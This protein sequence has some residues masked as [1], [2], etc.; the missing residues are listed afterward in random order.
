M[1]RILG[2]GMKRSSEV[3]L[4]DGEDG[5][6]VEQRWRTAGS[7]ALMGGSR[8]G[9]CSAGGGDRRGGG[10]GLWLLP[11]GLR[12]GVVGRAKEGR[13]GCSLDLERGEAAVLKKERRICLGLGLD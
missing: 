12:P 8:G 10:A 4:A 2:C 6:T 1:A 3:P 13:W 5:V 7:G 11:R 9:W